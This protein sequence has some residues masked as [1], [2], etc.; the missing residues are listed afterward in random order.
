MI[1]II[2]FSSLPYLLHE[3]KRMENLQEALS[4]FVVSCNICQDTNEYFSESEFLHTHLLEEH[5]IDAQSMTEGRKNCQQCNRNFNY[6]RQHFLKFHCIYR[7]KCKN[8]DRVFSSRRQVLEHAR[9]LHDVPVRSHFHETESAFSRRIKTFTKYFPNRARLTLEETF[10]DTTRHII[11]LLERQLALYYLI[12]FAIIV[13]AQ[14]RQE[15]ALGQ[16]IDTVVIPLRA[17]YKNIYMAHSRRDIRRMIEESASEIEI[18]NEETHNSGSGWILDFIVSQNLEVGKLSMNGG[19]GGGRAIDS[20]FWNKIPIKKRKYVN[21]VSS[22]NDEC[23][24]N[25]VAF[26]MAFSPNITVAKCETIAKQ[27]SQKMFRKKGFILPF[28]VKRVRDFE[29]KNNNLS[30]GINVWTFDEEVLIPIYRTSNNNARNKINLLLVFVQTAKGKIGHYFYVNDIDRLGQESGKRTTF[31]C[32]TCL[33]QFSRMT[34][35]ENHNCSQEPEL[36]FPAQGLFER[37]DS[38]PRMVDQVIFGV[39]DFESSLVPVTRLEN[40]LRFSCVNC[41]NGLDSSKCTH[42]TLDIHRQI[43]TTFSLLFVDVFGK[44][45]QHTTMSMDDGVMDIFFATLDAAQ[46]KFMKLLQRFPK[47][48]DYTR[49]ELAHFQ[50]SKNCYLCGGEFNSAEK[51]LSPVKDHCHYSNTFLGAAHDICNIR[52]RQQTRIPVFVHN[53]K[54]YDAHFILHSLRLKDRRRISALP[55]NME[56]FRTLTIDRIAF[57]DSAQLIPGALASLVNNLVK[58]DH[59]FPFLSSLSFCNSDLD[60]QLL[61]RKG[62]YPYEW[63]ESIHKLRT[64]TTLPERSDFFS[65]LTQTTVST[66]DYQ[67][68]QRVYSYFNCQNMLQYCELYCALD[69]VLLLE[70]IWSFRKV[71]KSAFGLDC[72]WY[73]SIPQLAYDCMLKTLDRGIQL[74]SDPDMNLLCEQNIRGGV[75]FVNIRHV[76]LD[77][78]IHPSRAQSHL[79]YID[80]NNLY[81]VAQMAVVP[82]G[83]YEWCLSEEREYLLSNLLEISET[84]HTGYILQVDLDY[85]PELHEKHSS[86]PLAPEHKDITFQDLS[87]YAQTCMIWLKG[88]AAAKRYKSK[89]LCSTL[90]NKRNYVVHYRLL[91]TYIRLGL[92]LTKVHAALKFTQAAVLRPF[93]ELCTERRKSSRTPTEKNIWKLCMNST[94]GKFIQDNR[95]HFKVKFARNIS[96]FNKSFSGNFYKGHRILNENTVAV[97]SNPRYVKMCRLYAVGFTILEL[98]K[99]HMFSSYYDYIQPA[100]GGEKN[101]QIVLT[102]TDSFILRVQGMG[103]ETMLDKLT[104]FMDYSNYPTDHPRFDEKFKAVPG[105]FKDEN[106]GNIMTE[107]VGL[108]SKCYM[109]QVKALGKNQTFQSVVCKGV[110]KEAKNNLTIDMYRSCIYDFNEIK[111]KMHC[112]RSKN[113]QLFTQSINKIALSSCDDKRYLLLCGK[114]TRPYGHYKLND[115]C[116]ECI[117]ENNEI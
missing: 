71:I 57:I 51:N 10:D 27:I 117:N 64:S 99:E 17:K 86:L 77:S 48:D 76:K 104:P 88:E 55:L 45:L 85:P 20:A 32:F 72:T 49:E 42:A 96:S 30:L 97:F 94:Y 62:V 112:I 87:P 28:S 103:R 69:T 114:H 9:Q 18:R 92:R 16:T 22:E 1:F 79:L 84:S 115:P 61:L 29:D 65:H 23:F 37:F 2:T 100:L 105:Y 3:E 35:K 111:T 39:L 44:V 46:V 19:G 58:S 8:C 89:K 91:Q 36:L 60:K 34:A 80:A 90:E 95:K 47:K 108:K 14:Y 116:T 98:S 106:S 5:G 12:R 53:F 54:N 73:I 4:T 109:T 83:D 67:H 15:D 82:T 74:I 24:F 78:S 13:F 38:F 75:S 70:V 113:H 26:G 11:R 59:S 93:I 7:Y 25:A 107:V 21:N 31:Q 50:A 41:A 66:E 40:A 43:P 6:A 52:R 102:D 110:G 63:A 56:K 33:S 101:V 81:S 68:A